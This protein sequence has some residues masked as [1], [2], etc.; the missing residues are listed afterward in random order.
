MTKMKILWMALNVGDLGRSIEF[1]SRWAS[2]NVLRRFQ[3]GPKVEIAFLGNGI[4]GETKLELIAGN[5]PADPP[6]KSVSIGFAVES[7][8][9]LLVELRQNG[10]QA[11][12]PFETPSS[13]YASVP[14]PDGL[15]VQFFQM[16]G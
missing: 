3:A 4:E 7:L 5:L 15:T 10:M 14:D 11:Q 6:G 9:T 8:E 13:F 12:G 1:Y 2:L 16:K